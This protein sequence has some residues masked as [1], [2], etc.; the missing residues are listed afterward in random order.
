MTAKTIFTTS[1][2][3]GDCDPAGIVWFPNFF[4]W[5]D[6]ASRNYFIQ[7]GVPP[8]RELEKAVGLVGTPLVSCTSKFVAPATYGDRVNIHTHIAEWG[9]TSFV[10]AH[11]VERVRDDLST[12]LLHCREVR[13]FA[14]KVEEG[15]NGIRAIPIPALVRHLCS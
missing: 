2:E 4:R 10:Q 1:V 6:A 12:T 9:R 3:F 13:V 5:I 11:V 8:W 7:R 15:S 14:A